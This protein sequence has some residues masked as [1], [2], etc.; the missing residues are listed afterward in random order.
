MLTEWVQENRDRELAKKLTEAL[1]EEF[2]SQ[3]QLDLIQ[4][5]TAAMRLAIEEKRRLKAEEKARKDAE[6]SDEE[7][8]K[9]LIEEEE[10][11]YQE[12]RRRILDADEKLCRQLSQSQDKNDDNGESK[13]FKCDSRDL[14]EKP[15]RRGSFE[16]IDYNSAYP[17][18]KDEYSNSNDCKKS[19][20][21]SAPVSRTASSN[22]LFDIAE[23]SNNNAMTAKLRNEFQKKKHESNRLSN[24]LST[25]KL[26]EEVIS[27][28]WESANADV[29]DVAGAV[30]LTI[31]LPNIQNL[32][33]SLGSSGK[34]VRIDAKRLIMVKNIELTEENSRY[35]AEFKLDGPNLKLKKEDLNYEYASETGLLH[36]YI[37]NVTLDNEGGSSSKKSSMNFLTNMKNN[38]FRIFNNSKSQD[39]SSSR[40]DYK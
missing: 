13:G 32:R 23:G 15:V 27:Q 10:R 19:A 16:S 24:I 35:L 29:D 20:R 40:R 26:N 18:C 33:V 5:E 36:V 39:E 12:E 25:S 6:K 37:E 2:K 3:Q 31:L 14:D 9:K 30:C 21:G 22:A 4:S 38:L 8:A 17:D 34:V 28:I 1:E 7:F 11:L